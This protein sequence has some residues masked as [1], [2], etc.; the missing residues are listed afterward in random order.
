MVHWLAAVSRC[1]VV[2]YWAAGGTGQR[3]EQGPAGDGGTGQGV[4]SLHQPGMAGWPLGL[5]HLRDGPWSPVS[6]GL[7]GGTEAAKMGTKQRE[8]VGRPE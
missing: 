7:G 3:G 2:W 6:P 8:G 1:V 5:E 4:P